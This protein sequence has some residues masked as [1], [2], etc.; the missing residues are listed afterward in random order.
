[1]EV[2]IG[3]PPFMY[4]RRVIGGIVLHYPV[5][6][7]DVPAPGGHVS[8]QPHAASSAV[9]LVEG[10]SALRLLLLALGSRRKCYRIVFLASPYGPLQF[11][12]CRGEGTYHASQHDFMQICHAS[13]NEVIQTCMIFIVFISIFEKKISSIAF[14]GRIDVGFRYLHEYRIQEHLYN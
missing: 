2:S 10:A 8:A 4:S 3:I 7:G 12:P 5:H 1:M 9:V 14:S 6:S 11:G 13:M